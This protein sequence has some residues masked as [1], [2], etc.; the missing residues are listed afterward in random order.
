M[1]LEW[2]TDTGTSG[3][4]V[5]SPCGD[6]WRIPLSTNDFPASLTLRLRAA[7][8]F[9]RSPSPLYLVAHVPEFRVFG[10]QEITGLSL[11]RSLSS[12]IEHNR[13]LEMNLTSV[14]VSR[15]EEGA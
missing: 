13:V 5:A 9:V 10:G 8:E 3:A 11:V 14:T 1:A 15:Q 2:E 12:G 7:G 4:A 6:S